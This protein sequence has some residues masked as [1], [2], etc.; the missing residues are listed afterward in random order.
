MVAEKRAELI[1]YLAEV[2]ND[3][4]DLF[5]EEKEPTSEQLQ[6]AIRESTLAL[7][8]TP[9]FLG[10]AYHN[11]A[12]QPMLDG[13]VDYLPTPYQVENHALDAEKEEEKVLLESDSD[14]NLVCLAFK[15]EEGRFGQ[16]TYLRVYQGMIK[17]G[18]N[19]TNARTGKKVKVSRL[20]RMHSNEME[21]VDQVGSGEICAL[22]GVECASGDTF[23]DGTQKMSMTSMFVPKPVISLSIQPAN[24]ESANFSKALARFQRE[25]PT[26]QVHL[27]PESKQTIISGMGE[28][29]LDIYVERMRR[30]YNVECITGKPR[31]AFRET[32]TK[33][34]PFEYTH[35]KQSGGSGQFARIKGYIEPIE[36]DER[37]FLNATVG[38][39]IPSQFIPAIEKV[40]WLL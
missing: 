18:M 6:N 33:M 24:R 38:M 4:A 8:F 31:V 36:E 21:D 28:L 11:K 29:H 17:K 20:V 13:V 22:F 37:D 25:D 27:D 7:Q 39:N 40:L 34:V 23:T 26:F 32:I 35:K 14:K 15:L 10:S 9:V 2:N 16:L 12:V 3:I 5:L 30:E 1:E 19:I